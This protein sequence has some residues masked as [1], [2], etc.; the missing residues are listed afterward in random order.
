MTHHSY[1]HLFNQIADDC[2][3]EVLYWFPLNALQNDNLIDNFTIIK[4]YIATHRGYIILNKDKFCDA[5][6]D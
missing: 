4:L 3:V 1:T 5:F 6:G 2:I